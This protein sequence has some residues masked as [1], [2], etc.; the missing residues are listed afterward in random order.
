[1]EDSI[2]VLRLARD[3]YDHLEGN[4]LP[5]KETNRAIEIAKWWMY[6]EHPERDR[7]IGLTRSS[8]LFPLSREAVQ[9]LERTAAQVQGQ[10]L[11]LKASA[12]RQAETPQGLDVPARSRSTAATR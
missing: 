6:T 3:L 10:P 1:M 2:E 8:I 9:R 4:P 12:D 7:P 5:L 11:E